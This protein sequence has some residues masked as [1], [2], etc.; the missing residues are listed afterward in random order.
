MKYRNANKPKRA[1][2]NR[3]ATRDK[4]GVKA[5]RR[6]ARKAKAKRRDYESGEK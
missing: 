4:W 3:D 6:N 2:Q 1:E 5:Q